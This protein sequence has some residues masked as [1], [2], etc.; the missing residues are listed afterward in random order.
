MNADCTA[1]DEGYTL[2]GDAAM[3]PQ[4]CVKTSH[5]TEAE[6]AFG[7]ILKRRRSR[8]ST[9]RP[10][11]RTRARSGKIRPTVLWI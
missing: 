10:A 9:C 1:C 7:T 4:S 2:V 11:T 5:V 3:G 8:C 6:E